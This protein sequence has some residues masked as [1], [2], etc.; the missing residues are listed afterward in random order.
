MEQQGNGLRADARRNRERIARGAREAFAVVGPQASFE[1]IARFTGLG[2]ATIYRRFSSR[3]E[4]IRAAWDQYLDEE[5]DSAVRLALKADNPW[6][7]IRTLLET[8]LK[9]V[10][11]ERNTLVA[12][13]SAFPAGS[14]IT[15]RFLEPL[16]QLLERGQAAGLLRP[17]LDPADLPILVKMVL[18]AIGTSGVESGVW[19]RYVTLV[20]DAMG[21]GERTPLPVMTPAD[22]EAISLP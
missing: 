18:S 5:V 21:T 11:T 19:R 4:L 9:S 16:R 17:D 2:T 3:E 14:I 7:A 20:L 6:T 15:S 13:Y 8:V 1:E 12:A 10:V 22:R